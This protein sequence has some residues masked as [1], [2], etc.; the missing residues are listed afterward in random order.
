MRLILSFTL[1]L[2]AAAFC[3]GCTVVAVAGAA[4]SVTATAVSTTAKVAG[5]VIDAA[6]PDGDDKE[7]PKE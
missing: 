3:S 2:I 6:I 7:K 1:L 4:V 5:A